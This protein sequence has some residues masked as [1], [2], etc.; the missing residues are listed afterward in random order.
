MI[1]HPIVSIYTRNELGNSSIIKFAGWD[2]IAIMKGTTLQM[3][4]L[5]SLVSLKL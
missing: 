1:D 4:H 2:E 5:D 3:N